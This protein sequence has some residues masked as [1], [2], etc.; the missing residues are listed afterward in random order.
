MWIITDANKAFQRWE[1]DQ[2]CIRKTDE[3]KAF[4]SSGA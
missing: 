4:Q 3:N 2:V 1:L